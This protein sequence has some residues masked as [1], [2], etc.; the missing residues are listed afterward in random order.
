V[1]ALRIDLPRMPPVCNERACTTSQQQFR[2]STTQQI[3]LNPLHCK[4]QNVRVLPSYS[5]SLQHRIQP[6]NYYRLKD[7]YELL[8]K[9]ETLA[10]LNKKQRMLDKPKA[11]Q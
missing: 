4:S 6:G 1:T 7:Y 11:K 8:A 10:L 5:Q 9:N 3:I 2:P